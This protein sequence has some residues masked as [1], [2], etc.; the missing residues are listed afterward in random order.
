MT[1]RPNRPIIGSGNSSS[2]GHDLL[3]ERGRFSI[4][5]LHVGVYVMVMKRCFGCVGWDEM[6]S[7]LKGG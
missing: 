5:F 1:H 4:V 3:P 2:S 7:G 6:G